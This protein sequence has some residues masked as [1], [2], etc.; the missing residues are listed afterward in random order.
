MKANTLI[1]LAR[2]GDKDAFCGL[3]GQYKDR[4]YRYGFYRLDSGEAAEDAVSECVLAAW[5]G[6]G[7]LRNPDAFSPWLFQILGA[8][9]SRQIRKQMEERDTMKAACEQ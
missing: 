9:C 7:G 6:I 4:L 1:E 5:K 2:A 8:C 3:Y